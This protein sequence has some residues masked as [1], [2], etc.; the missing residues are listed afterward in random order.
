[1]ITTGTFDIS[2]QAI[3]AVFAASG[4][5][6]KVLHFRSLQDNGLQLVQSWSLRSF[7]QVSSFSAVYWVYNIDTIAFIS[8]DVF[9]WT[10]KLCYLAFS[11]MS[12]VLVSYL[13][14]V[15]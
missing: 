6:S 11:I 2:N 9:P 5:A 13:H 1:M 4:F 10:I 3:A 7:T 14:P 8:I 12:S 15:I